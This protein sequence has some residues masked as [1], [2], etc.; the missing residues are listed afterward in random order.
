MACNL[1]LKI[2]KKL[3]TNPA[4]TMRQSW[5]GDSHLHNVAKIDKCQQIILAES[6]FYQKY[7]EIR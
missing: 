4:N 5:R 1:L 2:T 7:R 3:L 6:P